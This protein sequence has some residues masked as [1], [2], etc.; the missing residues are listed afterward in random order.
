M[1]YKHTYFIQLVSF[2]DSPAPFLKHL[3]A[4]TALCFYMLFCSNAIYLNLL[5]LQGSSA[6]NP[7]CPNT[8]CPTP[9]ASKLLLP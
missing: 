8:L 2:I 3:S 6:Q 7:F 5:L 1:Q 4:S 9:S